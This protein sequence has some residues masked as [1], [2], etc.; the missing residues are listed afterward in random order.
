MSL[1][2]DHFTRPQCLEL[3]DGIEPT[4]SAWKAEVLPLYE[5]SIYNNYFLDSVFLSRQPFILIY[6]MNSGFLY[7][8]VLFLL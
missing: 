2:W 8:H 4:S 3:Y 5:Y 1:L 7:P 6:I